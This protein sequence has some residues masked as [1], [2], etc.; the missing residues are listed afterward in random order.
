M[1]TT[2]K[3]TSTAA[4]AMERRN[5]QTELICVVLSFLSGPLDDGDHCG[6]NQSC[7]FRALPANTFRSRH[8]TCCSLLSSVQF[9]SSL[10]PP[11]SEH[12]V[13][14][15]ST[16]SSPIDVSDAIFVYSV[17]HDCPT[18]RGHEFADARHVSYDD[19]GRNCLVEEA[20][21]RNV[22]CRRRL[23][24]NCRVALFFLIS[25]ANGYL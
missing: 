16:F 14:G 24:G 22:C 8:V 19:R 7:C 3:A 20:R 2:P 5:S 23:A 1:S 12:H 13:D 18:Q 9:V 4:R 6:R 21:G 15:V 17:A 25:L 10:W 11:F